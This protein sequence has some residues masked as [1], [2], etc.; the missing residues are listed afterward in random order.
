MSEY[1]LS[2]SC[3]KRRIELKLWEY[4]PDWAV[5]C[6]F[7]NG[8]VQWLSRNACGGGSS[9][10]RERLNTQ[11]VLDEIYTLRVS[12]PFTANS[13]QPF[14]ILYQPA[15][16]SM[17]G[18]GDPPEEIPLCCLVQATLHDVIECGRA[19]HCGDYAWVNVHIQQV[20]PLGEIV[21]R[22]AETT[23]GEACRMVQQS[24]SQGYEKIEWE[25]WTIISVSAQGNVGSWIVTQPHNGY[26]TIVLSCDWWVDEDD[27]YAGN[28]PLTQEEWIQ[29][30]NP[31]T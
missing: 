5:V 22:F 7:G 24:L 10:I 18:W 15:L 25:E 6:G 8:C 29:L 20:I 11:P 19:D 12:T 16:T 3:R 1:V 28:R 4:Q 21:H 17:N 31:N 13:D 26:Q 14:W 2:V 23:S 9:E 27:L 30:T